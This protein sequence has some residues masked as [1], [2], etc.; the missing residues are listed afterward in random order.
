M[1]GSGVASRLLQRASA[2]LTNGICG[3]FTAFSTIAT[4][5]AGTTYT[6]NTLAMGTCYK[7]EYVATDNLGNSATGGNANVVKVS[8]DV[9]GPTGG[10][11]TATGLVGTGAAYSTST[12]VN[13]SFSAGTDPSGVSTS[14][15][16]LQRASAPLTSTSGADGTCGT[17]GSFTTVTGGTD[18]ASPKTDTATTAL[19]WRYQYVVTDNV[20]N[21]TTY[22]SSDVKVDTTAPTTVP[23]RTFGSFTNTYWDG[24]SALVYYRSNA[25]TGSFTVTA[26][27]ALD[28]Q[29]GIAAY[30]F[31]SFGTNWTSTPGAFGV[32]T[33]SWSGA[34]AAPGVRSVTATNNAGL[35][36]TSATFTP[37]VDNTAPTAGSVTYP[38]TTT[39]N[40]SVSVSFTT[41]TDSGS[42]IGTRLLQRASAT[43]TGSTCGSY[44]AWTTVATD[45][46]ASPYADTVPSSG[47]C[48]TYQYVVSDNVGNQT[49]ATSP[50]VVK[51]T[52]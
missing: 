3:T 13:L 36:A 52:P 26:N 47:F 33:Y 45:P 14:G 29:S 11:L 34:P 22:T 7:Y 9:T 42:G 19:C 28:A 39:T 1:L 15:N 48:Y 5:P 43:L 31:T 6:D 37:T 24:S 8:A 25:A 12:T 44:G 4:N 49:T 16:L 17:F 38:D 51:V 23:S 2:T 30:S 46:A 21:S 20:G 18:P 41:G 27:G 50:S 10:S 35:G 32:N 40:T